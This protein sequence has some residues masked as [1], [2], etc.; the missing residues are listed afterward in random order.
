MHS[1]ITTLFEMKASPLHYLPDPGIYHSYAQVKGLN[2]MSPAEYTFYSWRK[3]IPAGQITGQEDQ[4][5]VW[6][7]LK[8][9]LGFTKFVCNI[10]CIS[11]DKVVHCITMTEKKGK[12]I[13]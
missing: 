2:H 13:F 7:V 5:H 6:D 9:H 4:I 3:N 1:Q 12:K 11:A 10:P 8:A